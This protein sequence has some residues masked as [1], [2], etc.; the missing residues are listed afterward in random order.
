MFV[1][2]VKVKKTGEKQYTISI[3]IKDD[4]LILKILSQSELEKLSTEI[5]QI[6][7]AE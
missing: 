5:A 2:T 4:L 7:Q 1:E 6:L 3:A